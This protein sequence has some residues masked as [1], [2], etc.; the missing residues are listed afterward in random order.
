MKKTTRIL[1]FLLVLI[2]TVNLF[3]VSASVAD[4][5]DVRTKNKN[6]RT[7]AADMEITGTGSVGNMVADALTKEKAGSIGEYYISGLVCKK[8]TKWSCWGSGP[9]ITD[10]SPRR[11]WRPPRRSRPRRSGASY[12]DSH[13][14]IPS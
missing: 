12:R 10:S 14:L 8:A 6:T 4:A 5:K 9:S 1:S 13:P 2:L 11:G 3:P 7:E